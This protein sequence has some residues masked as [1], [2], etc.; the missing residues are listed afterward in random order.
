MNDITQNKLLLPLLGKTS[1][2]LS[3]LI[4]KLI[5]DKGISLNK[6]QFVL[7]HHLDGKSGCSQ[8]ALAQITAKDKSTIV[9]VI[10]SLEKK[11]LV[12]RVNSK[13]DKRVNNIYVTNYGK[14]LLEQVYPIINSLNDELFNL[15][16]EEET[17]AFISVLEKFNNKIIEIKEKL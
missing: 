6:E 15:L 16:S 4:D 9:R 10:N 14:E 1:H 12:L 8:N 2:R 7:L 3:V 13:E 11:N 17:M 5:E